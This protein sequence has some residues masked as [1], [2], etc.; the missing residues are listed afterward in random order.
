LPKFTDRIILSFSCSRR[1]ASNLSD[2]Q[3][4]K[5]SRVKRPTARATIPRTQSAPNSRLR[6]A[7]PSRAST[8]GRKCHLYATCSSFIVLV[9]LPGFLHVNTQKNGRRVPGGRAA[10]W[11]AKAAGRR[12]LGGNGNMDRVSG[13]WLLLL[14]ICLLA[15]RVNRRG[16]LGRGEG[17]PGELGTRARYARSRHQPE[18]T[19]GSAHPKGGERARPV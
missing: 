12:R 14:Q 5:L 18:D 10:G 17:S 1:R 9:P 8:I 16:R 11:Q 6:Q 15:G 4:C 19:V 3:H 2:D 13:T 7:P